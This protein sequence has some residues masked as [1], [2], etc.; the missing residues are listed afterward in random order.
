MN[1]NTNKQ[2]IVIVG[3]GV[4]GLTLALTLRRCKQFDSFQ[5]K[6]VGD[7]RGQCPPHALWEV[8]PYLIDDIR[9]TDWAFE[10][11]NECKII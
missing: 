6:I 1:N 11:L 3:R 8:P 2:S 9:A 5:I 10:S 7:R 4:T